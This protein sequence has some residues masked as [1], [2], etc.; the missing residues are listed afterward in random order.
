MVR[1]KITQGPVL[2][3]PDTHCPAMRKNSVDFLRDTQRKYKCK[4]VVH[5][6]D[7]VD[8][9]NLSYHER[10]VGG[11]SANEEYVAARKQISEIHKAFPEVDWLLGNHDS[12]NRRKATTFG[13]P[14]Y[15]LKDYAELFGLKKW[16][17]HPRYSTIEIDKVLYRHGDKGPGGK[18]AAIKNAT[19]EFQSLVIGHHH[20]NAGVTY[21]ANQQSLIFGLS[22]GTLSDDSHEIMQYG[23]QYVG[24]SIAGCGVVIDETHAIFEPMK[25]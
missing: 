20:I 23:K 13:I 22:V 15:L 16:R 8:F 17:V 4:K 10:E 21:Y 14:L 6:G 19:I 18:Q 11:L 12:L 24:K 25:L 3:I 9:Y 7:L 2:V 1:K 5:I